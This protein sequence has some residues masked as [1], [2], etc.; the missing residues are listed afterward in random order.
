MDSVETGAV[1]S[2]Q[3][4]SPGPIPNFAKDSATLAEYDAA[5]ERAQ[6]TEISDAESAAR[7]TYS[8][9]HA[10]A[11][12]EIQAATGAIEE[13]RKLADQ[14]LKAYAESYPDHVHRSQIEA[15]GFF[16]RLFTFGRASHLYNDAARAAEEV[17]NSQVAF[18]RKQHAEEEL[19]TWLTRSLHHA[20]VELKEQMEAPEWLD[21]F[22]A[23]PEIA[24]LWQRVQAIRAEREEYARRLAAGEVTPVEQRNRWLGENTIEPLRPTFDEMM[25]DNIMHFGDLSC[26]LFNDA[27]GNKFWLPYDRRLEP[28][29]DWVFDTYRVA[30]D[31][32]AKFTRSDEGR[33]V[34]PLDHYLRQSSDEADAR[35]QSRKRMTQ[36]RA[37]KDFA[38]DS[39][40]DDLEDKKTL[41]L[42]ATLAAANPSTISGA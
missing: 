10:A 2:E 28:L 17:L 37:Q 39:P 36:L 27:Q 6:Q 12:A 19:E 18:R 30:D 34:T 22:H 40:V 8:R 31:L 42:L 5:K 38:K 29:I 15:P 3:P 24:E 23:R 25:I 14:A 32:E 16:E 13:K 26:W 1:E 33:R 7:G 21:T 41:D 35:K 9:K 11:L 4:R 20:S